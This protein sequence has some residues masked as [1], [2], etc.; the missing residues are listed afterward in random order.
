MTFVV[1]ICLSLLVEWLL[2]D[3]ILYALLMLIALDFFLRTSKDTALTG[4]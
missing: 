4:A 2:N 3:S 1:E